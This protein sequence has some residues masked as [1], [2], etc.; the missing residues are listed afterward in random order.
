[1]IWSISNGKTFKRCQRQWF[2]K[3]IAANGVTK[4]PA[5]RRIYLLSKLQS[6]SSW[7]GQIVDDVISQVIIP[8]VISRR[9]MTLEQAKARAHSL[10]ER[11][12]DCARKHPIWEKEFSPTKLG[13]DFAAFHCMEYESQM[14][15]DEVKRAAQEIDSALA[16]LFAMEEVKQTLKSARTLVAQRA[17]IFQHSGVSVRAVPDLIAFFQDRP[18]VILDW[19]VHVF[20]IQEAW[21]QLAVYALAL[22]SCKPHKDF[23]STFAGTRADQIELIEVQLLKNRTRRYSLA[24]DEIEAAEAHIADSANEMSMVVDGRKANQLS[25]EDFAVANYSNACQSCPF[26]LCCWGGAA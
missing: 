10:F 24:A 15:E 25:P 2:Y 14:N 3:S 7:R 9:R 8:A 19:K 20:G 1:V 12:L 4:D 6:I 18:P 5:R 26:K 17:L 22:T 13:V 16:N 11:Q 23:P 21:L